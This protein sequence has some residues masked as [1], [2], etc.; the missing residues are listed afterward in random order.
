ME[1]YLCMKESKYAIS[2]KFKTPYDAEVF[3]KEIPYVWFYVDV[4]KPCIVT[5]YWNSKLDMIYFLNHLQKKTKKL[6]VDQKVLKEEVSSG[7]F[8]NFT[9]EGHIKISKEKELKNI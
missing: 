2:F 6:V 5:I 3:T 9:P 1:S 4:S 8:G 7:A